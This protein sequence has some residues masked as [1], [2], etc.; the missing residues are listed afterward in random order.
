MNYQPCSVCNKYVDDGGLRDGKFI[1]HECLDKNKN[2]SM[3]CGEKIIE[4]RRKG[5]ISM[6]QLNDYKKEPTLHLGKPECEKVLEY[7]F[8]YQS[9]NYLVEVELDNQNVPLICLFELDDSTVKYVG[10][11]GENLLLIFNKMVITKHELIEH[12]SD[13]LMGIIDTVFKD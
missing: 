1:C 9:E 3:S 7:R 13:W 2:Q 11:S 4:H 5:Y 10:D 12:C 8:N 6:I